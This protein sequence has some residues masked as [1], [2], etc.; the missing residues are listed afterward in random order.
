MRSY[1]HLP[2][3][4]S[5]DRFSSL[6]FFAQLDEATR[7]T[8]GDRSGGQLERLPDR[9]VSLVA[10]KEAVE[11]LAAVLGQARHRVMDV[12][13]LVDPR[14]RILVRVRRQIGLVGCFLSCARSQPV[15]ADAAGELGDPGLDRVVAAQRAEPLVDL[16]EDFLEDVLGVVL[17]EPKPLRRDR[18]DVTREPLY[19]RRP[20]LLVAVAAT[21]DELR[22]RNRLCHG[23]LLDRD[24]LL[25][26]LSEPLGH[27]LEELPGDLGVRLDE[28][29]E[30]P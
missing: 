1:A 22:G 2:T 6:E 19:E 12:E 9:P 8:A 29:P 18:V 7:N 25:L 24:L 14:D 21:G 13:R 11:D 28:G 5:W 4:L 10:C 16:R 27:H 30:L 26:R 3:R 23:A 17:P 15:D 20:R